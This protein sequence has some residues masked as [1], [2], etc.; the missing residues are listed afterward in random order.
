MT[1]PY[2]SAEVIH[3]S[4]T[5]SSSQVRP[6][7]RRQ[8]RDFIDHEGAAFAGARHGRQLC[9]RPVR[10]AQLG[11]RVA[12]ATRQTNVVM[13]VLYFFYLYNI[14]AKDEDIALNIYRA[15]ILSLRPS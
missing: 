15:K 11:Y 9:P 4:V 1:D 6:L 7:H 12:R 13:R 10:N 3:Q 8:V 2:A 5:W 14:S